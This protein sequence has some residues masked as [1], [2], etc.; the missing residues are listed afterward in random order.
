MTPAVHAAV[1]AALLAHDRERGRHP[2]LGCPYK[3]LPGVVPCW[4]CIDPSAPLDPRVA[5]AVEAAVAA[6]NAA[7]DADRDYAQRAVDEVCHYRNLAIHLGATPEQMRNEYDRKLC[8]DGLGAEFFE[9]GGF[10]S[11]DCWDAADAA[12]RDRDAWHSRA[13]KMLAAAREHAE[14][15]KYR[16]PVICAAVTRSLTAVEAAYNG[17]EPK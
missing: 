1:S 8:R 9:R 15:S 12:E 6:V 7:R 16:A 17:K 5:V 11:P 3:G 10:E 2:R 14:N 13:D 4:F